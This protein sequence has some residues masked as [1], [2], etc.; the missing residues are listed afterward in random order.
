MSETTIVVHGATGTQGRAIVRALRAAGHRIRAVARHPRASTDPAIEPAAADLLDLDAL[1][2]AYADADAVIVQLPLHF[3]ADALRQ[4]DV[5]LTALS[6]AGVARAVFNT[7]GVLPADPVGVP[8][9]DARLRLAARL[10]DAVPV[11]SVVAPAS[12]YLE[13]LVAPWSRILVHRDGELRYPLPAHLANPWVAADD[14]GAVVADLTVAAAPPTARY[15]A[16]PS[17]L[18]GP[19]VAAEVEGALGRRVR[20]HTIEPDEYARMLTPHVGPATAAGI[21]A[22][23]AN[24]APQADPSLL[25][26]GPTTVRAWAAR[27]DWTT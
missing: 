14:L 27:Q 11:A 25:V 18:T 3:A 7:G 4:A 8:F 10:P 13:N 12:T 20:W 22:A 17:A 19:Q 24:P 15:V 9:V 6:K 1:V 26:H 21:A 2:A 5:V 23:Y 16:G